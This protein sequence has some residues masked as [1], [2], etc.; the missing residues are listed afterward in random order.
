MDEK[1]IK[2]E[3]CVEY[4]EKLQ[5]LPDFIH[6]KSL[7][8]IVGS[9][10]SCCY[11]QALHEVGKVVVKKDRIL[12]TDKRG[13]VRSLLEKA[14]TT[15]NREDLKKLFSQKTKDSYR[16]R[17]IKPG[18]PSEKLAKD[19]GAVKT[20]W[21]NETNFNDPIIMEQVEWLQK[22]VN[23]G[24]CIILMSEESDSDTGEYV[25]R[26]QTRAYVAIT[27][28]DE[29]IL[30]YDTVENG[31]MA[32]NSIHEWV[33]AERGRELLYSI[34]ATIHI[35][36]KYGV[37]K[38]GIGEREVEELAG[39]LGFKEE[40]LFEERSE[41]Y[42]ISRRITDKIGLVGDVKGEGGPYCWGIGRS[43][44]RKVIDLE[45]IKVLSQEEIKEKLDDVTGF[46]GSF[47]KT[48]KNK[49]KMEEVRMYLECL[50]SI[51]ELSNQDSL[52]I[53]DK[54][55]QLQEQYFEVCFMF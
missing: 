8:S 50:K 28:R 1:I 24:G 15:N 48:R 44:Q 26:V 21:I 3:L 11:T 9:L 13:R 37:S 14:K 53:S 42:S 6:H 45:D 2:P 46:L 25:S 51:S 39:L 43:I 41:E 19:L 33:Y 38:I 32:Y 49:E 7:D 4:K 20:C 40:V 52:E 36:E 23:T 55:S 35:A 54:I 16:I 12:N 29:P 17:I 34:A 5:N 47:K 10:F 30:F 22:D 27:K 18:Y 31:N